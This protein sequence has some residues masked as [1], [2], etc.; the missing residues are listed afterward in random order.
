VAKNKKVL[1]IGYPFPLRHG[2]SPRLLGLAKYLPEFGWDPVVLTAPLDKAPYPWL[3]V[4]ETPYEDS[5]G[6]WKHIL[7]IDPETDVRAQMHKR[8]GGKK[9]HGFLDM[10]MTRMSEIINFPDTEKGWQRHAVEFGGDFLKREKMD[11][12]I[13]TSA[14]VSTHVIA[15]KLK[16]SFQLPWVAELRDLWSQNH[17]YPYSGLRRSFDRRLEKKLFTHADALV[18]V[19]E[20]WAEK[21]KALHKKSYVHAITNGFDPEEVNEP[22]AKLT[23]KFTITYT[24]L[25]YARQDTAPLFAALRELIDEKTVSPEDI[26]VRFYG[27]NT[28]EV[29]AI[30]EQYRLG[31]ILTLESLSRKEAVGKQRESQLLLLLDWNDP[32][33]KGVYPGKIFE[34]F[35]ARRPILAIGGASDDVISTLMKKTNVGHHAVTKEAIKEALSTWYGEYKANGSLKFQGSGEEINRYT[36]RN[37][38][39]KYAEILN[40]IT[41]H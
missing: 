1:I 14:P 28:D 4:I 22:P 15:G 16:T 41:P 19:S 39:E 9:G 33:E 32:E 21:L 38:A 20:P 40:K 23:G 6:I 35:A 18:T 12:I 7:R 26:S 13:S 29:S 5:L 25:V 17:N 10:L 31:E 2:G 27:S 8:M 24:G 36:Q 37:I 30:A 11:A 34:Y 3:R